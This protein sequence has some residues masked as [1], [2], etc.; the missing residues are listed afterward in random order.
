MLF[1]F[2]F[3]V[4]QAPFK[5]KAAT[6]G[7]DCALLNKRGRDRPRSVVVV[8]PTGGEGFQ[9]LGAPGSPMGESPVL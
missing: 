2:A 3:T 8:G 1:S 6:L 4:T 5:F 7:E 9:A